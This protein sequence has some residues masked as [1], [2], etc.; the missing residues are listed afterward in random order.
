MTHAIKFAQAVTIMTWMKEVFGF[1]I[2][3]D[4]GGIRFVYRIG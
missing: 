2:D 3:L 4:D 1:I